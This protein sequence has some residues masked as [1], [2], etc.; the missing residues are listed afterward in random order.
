[1][2]P[3]NVVRVNGKIICMHAGTHIYISHIHPLCTQTLTHTRI[4]VE[5][6]IFL[7]HW[8]LNITSTIFYSLFYLK[9]E[10][11]FLTE[12]KMPTLPCHISNSL[13]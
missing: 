7:N 3:Y 9:S 12:Y 5:G 10:N 4:H 13:S 2:M 11:F 6:Y 8:S 1:M